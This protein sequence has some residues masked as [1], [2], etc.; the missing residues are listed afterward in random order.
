MRDLV[1]L[2]VPDQG[3]EETAPTGSDY[4]RV[5]GEAGAIRV[6]RM[7]LEAQGDW[8]NWMDVCFDADTGDIYYLYV[9]RSCLRNSERYR[10]D[11]PLTARRVAERLALELD[12]T[13]R[14]FEETSTGALA[15]VSVPGGTVVYSLGC[16]SYNRLIDV[17][18]QC[19]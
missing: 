1:E 15:L 11:E 12:G 18:V 13:L 7:W 8:Q 9:S 6:C 17:K 14:H 10:G 3:R 19:A 4:T 16:V 2:C 5:I